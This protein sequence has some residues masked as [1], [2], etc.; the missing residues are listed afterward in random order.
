MISWDANIL[1]THQLVLVSKFV[2]NNEEK[3]KF[4][5]SFKMIII[6]GTQLV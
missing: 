2:P 6:L 1:S 5:S 4:L 3:I